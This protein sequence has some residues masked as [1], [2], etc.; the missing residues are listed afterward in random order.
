MKKFRPVIPVTWY[1]KEWMDA[2]GLKQIDMVERAGWSKS[3]ASLLYN[4][5]QDMTANLLKSASSVMN[6]EPYKLLMHPDMV[7]TL[8]KSLKKL[9]KLNGGCLC[10]GVSILLDKPEGAVEICQ[11]DMCRRW[12]GAFY[13]GIRAENATVTDKDCVGIYRSSEWAE[14][15]FCKRCGSSLWY[16]FLPTGRRS[17]LAGLFD[18]ASALP[19][20][21]E[22]FADE[23]A[24][25]CA[26]NGDHH[27]QSAAE[28]MAEA[29]AAGYEF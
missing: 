11:C 21:K 6:I 12:G 18:G 20:E 28:V 27:R 7:D 23:A 26:L 1:L 15:A 17:F 2:L 24:A 19:I 25:W 13:A 29:K 16:R 3:V 9:K 10:G 22:I 14:R 8:P 5:Q 4:C